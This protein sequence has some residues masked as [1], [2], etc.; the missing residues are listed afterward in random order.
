GEQVLRDEWDAFTIPR[1]REPEPEDRFVAQ[2]RN[3]DDRRRPGA[4]TSSADL[5][6]ADLAHLVLAHRLREVRALKGFYRYDML[7]L[8]APDLGKG[9]SWLP[10]IEVYGEGIFFS[11]SEARISSWET[12]PEVLARCSVLRERVKRSMWA[13]FLPDVTPRFVMLH[14]LAHLL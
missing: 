10:A 5:I 12:R 11:L 9:L 6:A 14:T 7:R 4:R 2:H 13:R 1:D 8:T 3:P